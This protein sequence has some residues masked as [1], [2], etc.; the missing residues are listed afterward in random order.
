MPT[1]EDN[2]QSLAQRL[3]IPRLSA[4]ELL[5]TFA[6]I[7]EELRL[8]GIARSSNNP[9][10]DYTEWLVCWKLG[11][12]QEAKSTTGFDATAK[13]GTK[14]EIKSRRVTKYN[15]SV[16]LSAI[17]NLQAKHFDYLIGVVYE[18]DFSI[19]YA[20]RVPHAV[21]APNS[22]FSR[23]SNAHLF[24]LTPNILDLPGVNDI[25]GVLAA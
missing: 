21:I 11:L 25:T 9:V 24:N 2:L 20:A 23:H 4:E 13:D 16:Q 5:Q 7:L 15:S 10:A 14:F 6:A 19:R 17:R 3:G 8:R 18:A 12:Q 22:R 1:P